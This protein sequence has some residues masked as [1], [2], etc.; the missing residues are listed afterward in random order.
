LFGLLADAGVVR[1]TASAPEITALGRWPAGRLRE[2]APVRIAPNWPASVVLGHL[3]AAGVDAD[4]WSLTADW[5]WARQPVDATRQ[6]LAAA[7]GTDA[8][9]RPCA[10]ELLAAVAATLTGFLAVTV[11]LN[12][13]RPATWRRLLIPATDSLGTLAWTIAVLFGWGGDHLHVFEVGGRRFADPLHPLEGADDE[14][15]ARLSRL[16]AAGMRK[17]AYAYDLGACWEHDVVLERLVRIEP[18]QLTLRCGAFAGD[19]PLEY[20]MLQDDD[21]HPI[22]DPIVTRPFLLDKVNATLA[23]GHYVVGGDDEDGPG[24]DEDEVEPW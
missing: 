17:F 4:L 23:S 2:Q 15:G 12:R 9:T 7:A 14:D 19:C 21:G 5:R 10:D 8:A 20:P 16:F 1:G 6:L 13:W 22:A 24:D 18:G 11:R 3:K